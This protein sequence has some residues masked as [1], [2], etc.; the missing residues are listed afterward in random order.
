VRLQ[1]RFVLLMVGLCTAFV[2]ALFAIRSDQRR[3]LG[4]LIGVQ[5]SAAEA[6][7]AVLVESRRAQPGTLAADYSLWNDMVTFVESGDRAWAAENIDVGVGTFGA[8]GA[9]V[10][11]AAMNPVYATDA[12]EDAT[13]ELPVAV[14][15]LK[16]RVVDE[17][18]WFARFHAVTDQGVAELYTAPIQPSDDNARATAPQGYF[19][20]AKL[21]DDEELETAGAIVGGSMRVETLNAVDAPTPTDAAPSA[22]AGDS[23]V[24]SRTLPGIDGVDV[25]R[26]SLELPSPFI[27]AART[28]VDRLLATCTAFG[29][30]VVLLVFVFLMRWVQ[31]PL[32]RIVGALRTES[33]EGLERVK[34]LAQ[35]YQALCGLIERSIEHKSLLTEEVEHRRLVEAELVRERDRAERANVAKGQFLANMSHEI[36]TPL[37]GVLGMAGLLIE[38]PLNE[39]QRDLASTIRGSGEALL[40]VLNDILDFSKIEAGKLAIESVPL[41]PRRIVDETMQLFA[42]SAHAKGLAIFSDLDASLPETV[43]GDPL[44]LRQVV[45]NLVGNAI[46]FTRSGHIV[47]RAA[48][49]ERGEDDVTL[50]FAVEDTGIGIPAAYV[51][52]LF[53][54]FSQA[55]GSTSRRF[56]GTGLGLAICKRLATLM[57]GRIDVKS[58]ELQGT[59]FTFTLKCGRVPNVSP[60]PARDWLRGHVA[61]VVDACRARADVVA[62]RLGELGFE[63]NLSAPTTEAVRAALATGRVHFALVAVEA[64]QAP[65]LAAIE[66]I[67]ATSADTKCVALAPLGTTLD[68]SHPGSARVAGTIALPWGAEHLERRL[69]E[70]IAGPLP[71]SRQVAPTPSEPQFGPELL[72]LLA[73]DNPVN[74]KVARLTLK[75]LGLRCEIVSNGRLAVEAVARTRFDLVLMDCQMPE[76]DGYEATAALRA[77]QLNGAPRIPI[78]AMTAN[79]MSSD[80]ERC[81]DAGMDDYIA[82]P[83]NFDALRATLARHLPVESQADASS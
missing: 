41:S 2:V 64:D 76:M 21:W 67:A 83:I 72:V 75:R 71:R 54:A 28:D 20:V 39:E 57:G 79:S 35:E 60:A 70:L 29:V 78:I 26:L 30:I 22:V 59:T 24:V 62:K 69:A 18:D 52:Q 65:A 82:K 50:E 81:L 61:L 37:N 58:V 74:Q 8:H 49:V 16:Q 36:R 55:D 68:V 6:M 31:S 34:P 51:P 73:E 19:V 9:W 48:L 23:I 44:R 33:A 14:E 25:A 13:L 77:L 32:R 53:D 15:R 46:K 63:V 10:F 38:T 43:L 40:G 5:R 80:R 56:G 42:A 7:L 1:T 27:G 3:S 66:L 47:V 45:S 12:F 4:H 17:R 11:D